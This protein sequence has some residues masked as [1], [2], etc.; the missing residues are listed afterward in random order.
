LS[1]YFALS[2][3]IRKLVE[4]RIQH[5]LLGIED[6][7]NKIQ[8]LHNLTPKEL[9]EDLKSLEGSF[10]ILSQKWSLEILYTLF[11]TNRAA[12]FNELKRVIGVNSRTLSDKLKILQE[13][14]YLERRVDPAPPL[15]VEYTLSEKGRS[16]ILLALPLLYYATST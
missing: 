11:L 7:L 14:D 3:E 12:R 9:K 6:T 15:R 2:S 10:N 16:T 1:D 4:T 13:A 8:E 5:T